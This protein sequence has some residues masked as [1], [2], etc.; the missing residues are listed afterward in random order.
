MQTQSLGADKSTISKIGSTDPH[1][2]VLTFNAPAALLALI[3]TPI[4]RL[5]KC[6]LNP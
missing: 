3:K 1:R 2:R 5:A 6:F 4:G